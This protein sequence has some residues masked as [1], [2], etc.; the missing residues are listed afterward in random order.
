MGVLVVTNTHRFL[1]TPGQLYQ[2]VFV[3]SRLKHQLTG[4]VGAYSYGGVEAKK[5]LWETWTVL[6][7]KRV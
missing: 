3:F 5:D 1:K 2:L 6:Y 4:L 7:A